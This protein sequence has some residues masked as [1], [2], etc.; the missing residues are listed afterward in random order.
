ML[1]GFSKDVSHQEIE[2]ILS[3][4]EVWY[5]T[6]RDQAGVEW[7]P[8]AGITNFLFNDLG[9]EDV[10]EF[11]DA[12]QGSFTDFLAAFPHMELRKE[13]EGESEKWFIKVRQL[14]PGPPRR[15]LLTVEK[16]EQLLT[17][18]LMKA[19]DATIDIPAL[20]FSIGADSKR[21]I[22]SLYFHIVK[23][24]DDLENHAQLLGESSEQQE[25]LMDTVRNLTSYL[26]VT[27][28]FEIVVLD[29]SGLSEFKPD[30]SVRV[31]EGLGSSTAEN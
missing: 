25:A 20:E 15:L 18:A 19:P 10:D 11:E 6:A 2:R 27:E 1:A 13:G 22:D 21:H 26:D 9:Y 12:I 30:D 17:T 23:A 16:S 31:L 4:V 8:V 14:Q 29:P 7:L 3:E 24:R 5:E 28:P